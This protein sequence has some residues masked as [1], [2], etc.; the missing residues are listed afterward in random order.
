MIGKKFYTVTA[1]LSHDL[2]NPLSLEIRIWYLPL[3]KKWFFPICNRKEFKVFQ[4]LTIFDILLT[5][6]L[7]Q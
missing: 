5:G 1:K 2:A 3:A 4:L 6:G 7:E